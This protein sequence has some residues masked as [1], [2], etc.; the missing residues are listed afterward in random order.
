MHHACSESLELPFFR[1]L[2]IY[3]PL[4]KAGVHMSDEAKTNHIAVANRIGS[5]LLRPWGLVQ[6]SKLTRP[7]RASNYAYSVP[8]AGRGASTRAYQHPRS[9]A[10]VILELA[11]AGSSGSGSGSMN[12]S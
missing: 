1:F 11:V 3:T 12:A 4:Q 2:K 9:P 8:A 5:H 6:S 10:F 7:Y